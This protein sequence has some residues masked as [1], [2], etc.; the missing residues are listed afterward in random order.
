MKISADSEIV[1]A[2]CKKQKGARNATCET[3]DGVC[4]VS[5]NI[6]GEWW[7]NY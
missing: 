3:R 5:L 6:G 4:C 7:V 1:M 2:K